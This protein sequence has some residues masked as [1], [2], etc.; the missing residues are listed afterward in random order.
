MTRSNTRRHAEKRQLSPLGADSSRTQDRTNP[1]TGASESTL[2][3][4]LAKVN[5][6]DLQRLTAQP[7]SFTLIHY[8]VIVG[9]VDHQLGWS[10]RRAC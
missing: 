3:R 5:P 1:E 6:A 8:F 10:G 9:F 2:R 7:R 4:V